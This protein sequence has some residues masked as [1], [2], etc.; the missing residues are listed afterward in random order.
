[1]CSL[2]LII[3]LFRSCYL[4]VLYV[5]LFPALVSPALAL[6]SVEQISLSDVVLYGDDL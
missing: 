3:I 2:F 5:I 4:Y 6:I 1:M